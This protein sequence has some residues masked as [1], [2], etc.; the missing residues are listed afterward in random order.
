LIVAFSSSSPLASVALLEEDG[1]VVAESSTEAPGAASGAL[2]DML[3][4]LLAQSG[5][6][7]Q[8][9]TLFASDIGP[10]SFIGT[11]VCVTIAK[12]LAY[13]REVGVVGATSFDL[14][15]PKSTVALPSKKG[16]FFVRAPGEA[17]IRS[18]S[19][20]FEQSVGYGIGFEQQSYPKASG[21][22]ALLGRL[23]VLKAE[24][25]LPEYLIEPS[26]STPKKQYGQPHANA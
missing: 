26:I 13:V 21:F 19:P 3:S 24:E 9:A 2:L 16:E 4:T 8:E 10:G 14:I 25:L 23:K 20:S 7:L 18:A 12:A 1:T 22:A 5:R 11:R 17:P 15:S 6:S